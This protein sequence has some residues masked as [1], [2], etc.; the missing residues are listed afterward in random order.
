LV[1][2]GV[3]VLFFGGEI[4]EMCLRKDGRVRAKFMAKTIYDSKECVLAG[5]LAKFPT[6]P[7]KVWVMCLRKV[8]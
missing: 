4:W 6:S 8:G 3:R 1:L 7:Y 5:F 2:L